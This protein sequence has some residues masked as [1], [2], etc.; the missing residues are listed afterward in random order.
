MVIIASYYVF[1]NM[2][3]SRNSNQKSIWWNFKLKF[4]FKTFKSEQ[5]CVKHES[6]LRRTIKMTYIIYKKLMG[7]FLED[8]NLLKKHSYLKICGILKLLK[9]K[10]IFQ[11]W[12]KILKFQKSFATHKWGK[13]YIMCYFFCNFLYKKKLKCKKKSW[14]CFEIIIIFKDKTLNL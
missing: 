5:Q 14:L 4:W 13:M 1:M 6:I 11:N 3:M 7:N 8:K 10:E 9:L 12:S 2:W